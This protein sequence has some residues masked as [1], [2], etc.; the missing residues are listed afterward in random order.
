[1][2]IIARDDVQALLRSGACLIEVLPP[3]EYNEVHLTRAIN[4]PLRQLNRASLAKLRPTS[5]V[6]VYCYDY[7]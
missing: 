5:P 2:K 1:M 6:I 7:Q 3:K 4:I